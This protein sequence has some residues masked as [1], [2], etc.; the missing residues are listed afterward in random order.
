MNGVQD[1]SA[2][3]RLLAALEPWLDQV[4]IVGGWAHQLYRLH[5]YAQ[6]LNYP[7]LTTLD[8]DV[9]VPTELRVG[10]QDL[11]ERLLAEGFTEEFLGDDHP[12]ATHYHLGQETSGF[13]AEFLPP[14]T[15]NAYDRKNKRKATME[16]AGIASQQLRHIELLLFHPWLIDLEFNGFAAKIR[17]ANPVSFLAQKVLIHEKRDREDRA[18]DILY[19]H[20]TIE[21]F[22]ARLTDLQALWQST[23]APRLHPRSSRLVAKASQV[24]FGN[25]SDD[26]RRAAEISA[27]RAL[28][29]ES[30]G[31]ACRYG[32]IKVFA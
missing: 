30:I 6:E 17:A 25:L 12:P 13:Y 27:E 1:L 20:D 11:R 29:P 4:V 2:F 26:I 15:G 23:V 24:L 7:P 28:T 18:K 3:R 21:V 31:E 19:M 5:P 10:E 32:F 8:T 16:I 22:G 9:A 14:L